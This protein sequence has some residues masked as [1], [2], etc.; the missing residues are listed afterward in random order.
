MKQ[1][2]MASAV[3][4]TVALFFIAT[5]SA[6]VAPKPVSEDASATSTEEMASTEEI[7]PADAIERTEVAGPTGLD[8]VMDGSSLEAFEKSMQRVKATSSETEYT[9][10]ENAFNYLLVYDLGAQSSRE[11]LAARLDG[12]TG[13]EIIN[14]VMWRKSKSG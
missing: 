5:F 6:C 12:K 10:L 11:K 7:V 8:I 9:S 2:K 4:I 14:K 1:N 3:L 13:R